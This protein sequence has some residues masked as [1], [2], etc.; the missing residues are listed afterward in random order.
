MYVA[1][2]YRSATLENSS[3]RH[4]D[5][6]TREQG[7]LISQR[8]QG[9]EHLPSLRSRTLRKSYFVADGMLRQT[10]SG[11]CFSPDH[12]RDIRQYFQIFSNDRLK[13]FG[14]SMPVQPHHTFFSQAELQKFMM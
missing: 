1:C 9:A 14:R 5:K 11:P 10:L 4:G 12:P 3:S 13:I 7:T 6:P 2:G 8:V